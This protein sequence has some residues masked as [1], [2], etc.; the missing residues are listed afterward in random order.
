MN[1]YTLS[2]E[3]PRCGGQ[4][5]D[6]NQALPTSPQASLQSILLR[7]SGNRFQALAGPKKGIGRAI[8]LEDLSDAMRLGEG[9]SQE[10]M[11]PSRCKAI[12]FTP[13]PFILLSFF[14][15]VIE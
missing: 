1:Y 5:V 3:T 6:D 10:I 7:D 11:S 2:T 15:P 14:L 4:A 8:F 12:I 13:P 9:P